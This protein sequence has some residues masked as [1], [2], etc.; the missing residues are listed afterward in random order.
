M[1][2]DDRP[3]TRQETWP[4]RALDALREAVLIL[5]PCAGEGE[6]GHRVA[7]ANAAATRALGAANGA[8]L[9]AD[10]EHLLELADGRVADTCRQVARTRASR[11]L[12]G[13]ALTGPGQLVDLRVEPLD[14]GLLLRW[15]DARERSAAEEEL[16][17]LRRQL[18]RVYLLLV[19]TNETI[20]RTATAHELLE[21]VC[22]VAVEEGGFR[23]AW[24]G[25][26]D[27]VEDAVRPV[28]HAGIAAGYLE[29]PWP[30][31]RDDPRGR[32]PTASAILSGRPVVANDILNDPRMAPWRKDALARGYSSSGAFPLRLRDRVVACLNLYAP[33]PGAFSPR[34]I[35]L[36]EQLATDIGIA[37][38]RYEQASERR[39]SE[40]ELRTARA[41]YRSLF[42]HA[43]EGIF[44]ASPD[45]TF[46]TVNPALAA[47]F[48]QE[49]AEAMTG[50]RVKVQDLF[51]AQAD[52]D[53]ILEDLRTG[54]RAS[55]IDA[56]LRR[57]DGTE[58]W[59]RVHAVTHPD[60]PDAIQGMV[61]DVTAQRHVEDE[62][63]DRLHWTREISEAL[64]DRR[65]VPYAQPIFDLATGEETQSEL[66]V[67]MHSTDA[68]P[69]LLPPGTFLPAAERLGLITD[70]DRFML[71]QAFDLARAGRTVQVNL[72]VLSLGEPALL[73]DLRRG[74][75]DGDVDPARIVFELT[76][77]AAARNM[78]HAIAFVD[79]VRE[80]G[81][82]VALDDFG[83]GFGTMT[84]LHRFDVQYLKIDASF[85]GGL[86]G[87]ASD[88]AVVRTIVGIAREHGLRTIAEGVETHDVLDALRE[89]G[90][91][92]AQGYLLGRPGPLDRG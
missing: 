28:A 87:S 66:L 92:L 73:A 70:I 82:E 62:L 49:S 22:R 50:G 54:G 53:A 48:A 85:V 34:E 68:P 29:R 43:V 30:L 55:G 31:R 76:E 1:S 88:T 15:R 86:P 25:E 59:G 47:M 41:R 44:I 33:E 60:D 56:R 23:M 67:R 21:E 38:E 24:A 83:T 13:V 69:R 26:V 4:A 79:A 63:R 84:Y 89:L 46:V 71:G 75:A 6:P 5:A 19:R 36:F 18:S 35:E 90:V 20:L 65:L 12:D 11:T 72:S 51:A 91:D 40:E 80:A 45:G 3:V 39:R 10:L 27:P 74:L 52:L 2:L 8:V 77:S 61:L 32:G 16:V 81:C 37:L 78:E 9:G 57:R 17:V 7:H 64:L 14:G 58:F 42:E